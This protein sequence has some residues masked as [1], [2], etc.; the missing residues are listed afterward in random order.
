MILGDPKEAMQ[1]NHYEKLIIVSRWVK[2]V[3]WPDP[4]LSF[5][6]SEISSI[7]S[8]HCLSNALTHDNQDQC[9]RWVTLSEE[10]WE[11]NKKAYYDAEDRVMPR[12]CKQKSFVADDNESSMITW[13]QR[14]TA[15]EKTAQGNWV[16]QIK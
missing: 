6:V 16:R 2:L 5:N 11:K 13:M 10:D 8:L 1:F 4:I 7:H 14:H 15:F 12:T 9:C 3:N